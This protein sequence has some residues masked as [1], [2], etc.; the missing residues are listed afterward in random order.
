MT[1]IYNTALFCSVL[2]PLKWLNH[3]YQIPIVQK[4][5]LSLWQN[6]LY[7]IVSSKMS[8]V[9]FI[10]LCSISFRFRSFMGF[11]ILLYSLVYAALCCNMF[12]FCSHYDGTRIEKWIFVCVEWEIENCDGAISWLILLIIWYGVV[13]YINALLVE[14]IS[15][16]FEKILY[17][18]FCWWVFF[19]SNGN[20]SMI[21]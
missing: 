9:S 19:G 6:S 21:L 17:V 7:R 3:P 1:D 16:A 13:V 20:W 15:I 5:H 10:S 14:L 11:L 8:V 12:L 18:I 4:T 2:F